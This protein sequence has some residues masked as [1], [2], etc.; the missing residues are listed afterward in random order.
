MSF[1]LPGVSLSS[2]CLS[3][4]STWAF[5]SFQF[6]KFNGFLQPDDGHFNRPDVFEGRKCH[7]LEPCL[8][9]RSDELEFRVSNS[10][11]FH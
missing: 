2:F 9:L 3:T 8:S 7:A 4:N 11:T 6:K 10:L 1:C 5:Q